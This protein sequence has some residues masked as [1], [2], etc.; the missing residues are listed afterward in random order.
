[1]TLTLH[2]GLAPRAVVV[3]LLDVA[4]V[5][6]AVED[7]VAALGA[8]AVVKGQGND[9]LHVLGV[10]EGLDGRVEVVLVR[11]VDALE[12]GALRVEQVAVVVAAAD[13]VLGQHAVGAGARPLP[14]AAEQAQL[15]AAPV[16]LRTDVG[17]WGGKRGLFEGRGSVDA[18]ARLLFTSPH[19]E[20]EETGS[21]PCN[22]VA[23]WRGVLVGLK[24]G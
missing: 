21:C 24:M 1:M 3:D 18:P 4:K 9:V 16:V 11:Q 15:L 19:P 23:L 6:V 12:D 5:D 8:V 20:G 17:A 22:D 10:L 14:A 7:A 2:D 13:A